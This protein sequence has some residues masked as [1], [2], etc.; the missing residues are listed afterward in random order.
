M[1]SVAKGIMAIVVV[2]AR[3]KRDQVGLG[4]V[5]KLGIALVDSRGQNLERIGTD[6]WGLAG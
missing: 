1:G 4:D 2:V 5:S 3:D 6:C